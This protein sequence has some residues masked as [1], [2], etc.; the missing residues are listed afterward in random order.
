[1]A[2]ASDFIEDGHLIHFRWDRDS[3]H[4]VSVTCPHAGVAMCNR[5]RERCVVETYVG[6]Y[7]EELNVGSVSID[8][9]V[10]VAWLAIGGESDLDKEFA[11]LWLMPVNDPD[12]K[13]AKFMEEQE[14]PPELTE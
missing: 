3:V 2:K 8:G 9:P 14:E 11:Q 1:M 13:A 10:E 12:F 5:G 4:I 7:G 6:T